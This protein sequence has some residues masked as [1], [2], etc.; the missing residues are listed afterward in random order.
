MKQ[1]SP[2][3]AKLLV[4]IP[5]ELMIP[6][7]EWL[8][9]TGQYDLFDHLSIEDAT[10]EQIEY[11]LSNSLLALGIVRLPLQNPL[12]PHAVI[13]NVPFAVTL[14]ES[15]EAALREKIAADSSLTAEDLEGLEMILPDKHSRA[16]VVV[17]SLLANKRLRLADHTPIRGNLPRLG[18]AL[19][20]KYNVAGAFSIFLDRPRHHAVRGLGRY[21][22]ALVSAPQYPKRRF[23]EAVRNLKTF[24]ARHPIYS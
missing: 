15:S 9:T 11:E 4:G 17:S 5:P 16:G 23:Q 22:Y 24:Y 13:A 20:G 8:A 18:M 14:S 2:H 21:Q 6:T 19:S 12:L 3:P 10:C 1:L 7:V